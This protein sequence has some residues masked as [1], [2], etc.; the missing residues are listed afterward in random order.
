MTDEIISTHLSNI[1]SLVNV[2]SDTNRIILNHQYD[3]RQQ[4]QNQSTIDNNE[5]DIEQLWTNYLTNLL[6]VNNQQRT[7]MRNNNNSEAFFIFDTYVP[8]SFN[9]RNTM[10]HINRRQNTNLSQNIPTLHTNNTFNVLHI[11]SDNSYNL[12]EDLSNGNV[13]LFNVSEF[14]LIQEPVNDICPITRE[15][16]YDNQNVMVIKTCKHIFNTSSLN[17]WL[18]NHNTCPSCRQIITNT[19]PNTN[20]VTSPSS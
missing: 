7:T 11:N 9:L 3:A 5:Q 8:N 2:V 12:Y 15:R 16:F 4:R 6:N 17:I 10:N 18:R 14:S 13:H 20:P 19:N 1:R